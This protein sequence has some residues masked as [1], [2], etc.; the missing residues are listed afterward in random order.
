MPVLLLLLPQD[1][2]LLLVCHLSP[3]QL[4][5]IVQVC[6]SPH[7]VTNPDPEAAAVQLAVHVA[8]NGRLV[9]LVGH[10]V[11]L[12]GAVALGAPEHVLTADR[13][14]CKFY[15]MTGTSVQADRGRGGF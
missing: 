8:P 4:P 15:Q 13:Q 7:V 10:P 1:V 2:F 11:V 5:V 9:Q 14:A 3:V 12:E 6:A